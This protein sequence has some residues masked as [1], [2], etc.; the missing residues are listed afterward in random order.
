LPDLRLLPRDGSIVYG[1]GRIDASGRVASRP[2]T[3]ALCWEPG[4]RLE[5]TLAAG[6][7]IVRASPGGL[8]QAPPRPAVIIPAC[9]RRQ[10]GLSTG[11][12]VLL[13]AAPGHA[14]VIAYPPAA[15][16]EMIAGYHS[17]RHDQEHL[18]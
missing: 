10:Y 5:V 4:E 7:V 11:D 9:A 1:F 13:A 3:S 18:R 6:V 17:A 15:L 14:L 2:V 12:H 8:L 16:D